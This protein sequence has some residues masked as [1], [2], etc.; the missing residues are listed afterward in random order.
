LYLSARII[1]NVTGV[2]SFDQDTTFRFTQ[3]DATTVYLQLI[4]LNKDKL[5]Q[6]FSLPGRRYVA[7][8]GAALIVTIPNIVTS[9]TT[10]VVVKIASQPFPGDLSIWS[11]PVASTD[12]LL[13][14]YTLQLALTE[15]PITTNGSVLNGLSAAPISGVMV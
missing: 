3:G 2:N 10:A 15:G 8:T 6:G 5:T 11:F 12:G 13:G 4:D 14:T 9:P 7:A 1:S